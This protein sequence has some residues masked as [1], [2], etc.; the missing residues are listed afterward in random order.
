[1][2]LGAVT[3]DAKMPAPS[4]AASP[5][6]GA[7]PPVAQVP[8]WRLARAFALVGLCAFGGV[9][10]WVYR[11]VV[12]KEQWLDK[13]E[14]SELWSMGL[15]LPG[16]T[17]ANIAGML[18]YRLGGLRGASAAVAG[19]LAPPFVIVIVMAL[20][21]Q[22]FGAIP[23]VHGMVRGITAIAAGLVLATAL[24]LAMGQNRKLGIVV[25]GIPACLAVTVLQWP[26][27]AVVGVLIP[28]SFAMQWRLGR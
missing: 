27:F 17:S 12:E 26:L 18:G 1:M 4:S 21:Y 20:L 8:A 6:K 14:F 10:P 11:T 22:R 28:L 24:K 3:E 23:A 16:A 19:L 9:M 2:R 7:A 13:A 5:R 15:I 25:F